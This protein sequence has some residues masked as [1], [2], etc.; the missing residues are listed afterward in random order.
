M[1]LDYIL[2]VCVDRG[3][4][5]VD[6]CDN[7]SVIPSAASTYDIAHYWPVQWNTPLLCPGLSKQVGNAQAAGL[8]LNWVRL[9]AAAL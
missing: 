7:I 1:T 4:C 2:A 6:A 8:D 5:P 3:L 9:L